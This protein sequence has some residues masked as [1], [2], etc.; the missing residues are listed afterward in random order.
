MIHMG[1]LLR[2][3]YGELKEMCLKADVEMLQVRMKEGL[4][5]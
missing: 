3:I 4:G 1:K 2:R 5:C